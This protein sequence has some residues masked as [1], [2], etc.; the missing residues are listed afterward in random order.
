MPISLI[1]FHA[2]VISAGA[3]LVVFC[4]AILRLVG[5]L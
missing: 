3:V 5:G 1:L 2:C 4:A